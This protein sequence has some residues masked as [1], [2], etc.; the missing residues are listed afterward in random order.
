MDSELQR[1]QTLRRLMKYIKPYR[2]AFIL[3]IIGMIGYAA[4][5]SFFLSQIQ[6][7]IDDGLTDQ[8]S[9][10]LMIGAL[11]VPVIFIVRGIFNFVSSY[12]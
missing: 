2:G 7:L 5:D 3:S 4:V 1:K 12:F 6:T 8:N 11:F 9:R 10:I